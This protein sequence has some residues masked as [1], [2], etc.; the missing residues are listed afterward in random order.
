MLGPGLTGPGPSL[1][2]LPKRVSSDCVRAAPADADGWG[3]AWIGSSAWGVWVV[4][5]RMSACGFNQLTR[6]GFT[7]E[8][9]NIECL[10]PPLTLNVGAF[11]FFSSSNRPPGPRRLLLPC[12]ILSC[13][14]RR[15]AIHRT[16]SP[17]PLCRPHH[18]LLACLLP[19]LAPA[20]GA[21]SDGLAC[22]VCWM[23]RA[24]PFLRSA[25]P[26]AAACHGRMNGRH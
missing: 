10:H 8:S 25:A 4:G 6:S 22:A 20:A 11:F 12:P 14:P 3:E 17:P 13:P 7:E 5:G 18:S 24:N 19:R 21:G 9:K 23:I 26:P 2:L 1:V 16:N 15:L